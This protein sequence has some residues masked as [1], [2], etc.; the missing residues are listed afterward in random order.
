MG[1]LGLGEN[2]CQQKYLQTNDWQGWIS[3]WWENL[4]F[5]WSWSA[6]YLAGCN[7]QIGKRRLIEAQNPSESKPSVENANLW[8]NALL[9]SFVL[10]CNSQLG[11]ATL[12]ESQNVN[13]N[14]PVLRITSGQNPVL[15]VPNSTLEVQL[16]A[17]HIFVKSRLRMIII[18][19]NFCA[20]FLWCLGNYNHPG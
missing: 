18:R 9:N 8:I 2:F 13:A 11:T 10:R 17:Q 15:R 7:S 16:Q 3:Q 19:A 14:L 1:H 4:H 12:I 6:L 20:T 5:G